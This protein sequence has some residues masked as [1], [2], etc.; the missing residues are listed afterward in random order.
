MEGIPLFSALVLICMFASIQARLG[1]MGPRRTLID[2]EHLPKLPKEKEEKPQPIV[3]KMTHLEKMYNFCDLQSVNKIAKS[4]DYNKDFMTMDSKSKQACGRLRC[5]GKKDI[6]C[7]TNGKLNGTAHADYFCLTNT[8]Q[9]RGEC[10]G[11]SVHVTHLDYN[12]AMDLANDKRMPIECRR[13]AECKMNQ[14]CCLSTEKRYMATQ[15]AN[16]FTSSSNGRPWHSQ[17]SKSITCVN[18]VK[19]DE[20]TEDDVE[21]GLSM[22]D[23]DDIASMKMKMMKMMAEKFL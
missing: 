5:T 16:G 15:W 4:K 19:T 17:P 10:P 20:N 6:C 21:M 3:P 22:V 13:D 8:K 12:L 18:A 14:K 1:S 11:G 7:P 23:E 2:R 9:H